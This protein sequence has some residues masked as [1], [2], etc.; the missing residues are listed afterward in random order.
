MDAFKTLVKI[1]V[2]AFFYLGLAHLL[3]H[4]LQG[5]V[6]ARRVVLGFLAWW[7]V[8]PPSD[9]T[10]MLYSIERYRGHCRGFEFNWLDAIGIGLALA[11][12]LEKRRDFSFFLL[13]FGFGSSGWS[14]VFFPW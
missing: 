4:Y 10:L 13:G 3:G 9:F 7:L 14:R 12:L 8:R 6:M 11:A 5:K 2:I 1:L